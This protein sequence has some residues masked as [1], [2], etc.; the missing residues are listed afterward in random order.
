MLFKDD[1]PASSIPLLLE[2]KYYVKTVL[3]RLQGVCFVPVTEL[4]LND[5]TL[6]L[7]SLSP[8][9]PDVKYSFDSE[10]GNTNTTCSKNAIIMGNSVYLHME[11][12]NDKLDC[13]SK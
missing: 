2:E 7:T 5:D 11:D 6:N 9:P 8:V 3:D 1:G 13:E 12:E 10:G 4:L